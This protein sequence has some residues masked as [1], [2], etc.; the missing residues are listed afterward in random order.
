MEFNEMTTKTETKEA[1]R[2]IPNEREAVIIAGLVSLSEDLLDEAEVWGKEYPK[3][4]GV[5]S[6]LRL[7]DKTCNLLTNRYWSKM[8]DEQREQLR[9]RYQREVVIKREYC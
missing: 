3:T 9:E 4:A 1:V 6:K 5:H 8:S 7:F 2:K